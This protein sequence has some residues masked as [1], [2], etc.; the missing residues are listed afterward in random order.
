[1]CLIE[2]RRSIILIRSGLMVPG[3][4]LCFLCPRHHN[5]LCVLTFFLVQ[6][7]LI[8]MRM[9]VFITVDLYYEIVLAEKYRQRNDSLI[10]MHY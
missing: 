3:R 1:M 6:S 9:I 2:L 7:I 5:F 8:G 4:S 10:V